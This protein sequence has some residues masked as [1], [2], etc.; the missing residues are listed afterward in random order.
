MARDK[1][2]KLCFWA[3]LLTVLDTAISNSIWDGET[4]L[5]KGPDDQVDTI[6]LRH[7]RPGD[8]DE[9]AHVL[10]WGARFA[11][12]FVGGNGGQWAVTSA[13]NADDGARISDVVMVTKLPESMGGERADDPLKVRHYHPVRE[14]F[15][16]RS[17]AVPVRLST[18]RKRFSSPAW[19]F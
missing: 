1:F 18:A 15:F 6:V 5:P 17:K 11:R 19:W 14:E 4:Q 3:T 2:I 16:C 10:H 9:Q 8:G 12:E 13:I 7:K